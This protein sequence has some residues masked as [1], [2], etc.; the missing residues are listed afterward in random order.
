[1]TREQL[2]ESL[3]DIGRDYRQRPLTPAIVTHWLGQFPADARDGILQELAHVLKRTYLSEEHFRQYF[4]YVIRT[5]RALDPCEFWRSVA[6]LDVQQKG[7]SQRNLLCIFSQLLQEE[8]GFA[9]SDC[10]ASAQHFI[11]LDDALFSG[12]R[13]ESDLIRWVEND[14]PGNA[15]VT[16]LTLARH[17][18]GSFFAEGNIAKAA[19][20]A[21]KRI[22][23]QFDAPLLIED[24]IA[25]TDVSDV[26][27]PNR[28]PN[29]TATQTYAAQL[30]KQP[31]LRAPGNVGAH[32]FFSSEAG[33]DL[34]EQEF[35]KA[36]MRVR[37]MCPLLKPQH[38]PLGA[39]RQHMLG[40]GSTIVTFRNCPNNAPLALWAGHPWFPLFPREIN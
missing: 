29:D 26:L 10:G 27:R 38:R 1:M 39:T 2:I 16:I 4:R 17:T 25:R 37:G 13:I 31:L 23:L 7:N 34:L 32:A 5:K 21:G 8:C 30:S 3:V 11:Y 36:G 9:M 24:R 18:Q 14:A 20:A 40:F 15:R 19:Q 35:L 12:G 6:F 22:A 28:I 33:R